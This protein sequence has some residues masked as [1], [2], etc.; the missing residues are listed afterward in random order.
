MSVRPDESDLPP[1]SREL[2]IARVYRQAAT[3]EPP[4]HLDRAIARA[5]RQPPGRSEPAHHHSWWRSWQLPFAVAAVGVVSV[6]LVTLVL[7]EGGER[8]TQPQSSPPAPPPEFAKPDELR[9][10]P[11]APSADAVVPNQKQSRSPVR[12]GE[13]GGNSGTASVTTPMMQKATPPAE[14]MP[15]SAADVPPTV[16]APAAA[17]EPPARVEERASSARLARSAPATT[18]SPADLRT[19]AAQGPP[20]GRVSSDLARHLKQLESE[21]PAAWIERILLVRRDGRLADADALLAEFRRR[22][23]NEALP[24]ELQ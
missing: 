9:E 19:E 7:D 18:S 12:A 20:P 16:A 23:P 13:A 21:P 10:A 6:S 11:P 15:P 1:D 24:A 4:A 17:A 8:L 5:A 3:E 14:V 2:Q 22:Y